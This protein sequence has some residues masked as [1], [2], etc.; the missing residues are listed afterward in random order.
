MAKLVIVRHAETYYN[1]IDRFSGV[2]NIP[3]SKYG[4]RTASMIPERLKYNSFSKIYVS[5]LSRSY[6]TAVVMLANMELDKTPI[7]VNELDAV[8][9]EIFLPIYKMKVLNERSYGK[10]E[11]MDKKDILL[12]YSEKELHIWRRSFKV[13]PPGGEALEEIV[14]RLQ[15]FYNSLLEDMKK[16]EDILI[17]AHQ[18]SIRALV[19]LI[20]NYSQ[21]EIENIEF[22][23][24]GIINYSYE[25]K[26]IL[27][28][29]L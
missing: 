10:L 20:E 18:N 21:E 12:M 2:L 13:G 27:E 25:E 22:S 19:Y 29:V 11:N 15:P 24:G 6:E 4:I 23:N 5:E 14:D 9:N 7:L 16:N 26:L 8:D 1:E 28:D 3:L 17:V